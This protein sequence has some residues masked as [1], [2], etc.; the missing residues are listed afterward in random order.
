ML[1][2][3]RLF[4]SLTSCAIA[5]TSLTASPQPL[6]KVRLTSTF[7]AIT[8]ERPI[9]MS[10]APDDSGRLFVIEQAGRILAIQKG[11]DGSAGTEFLNI[12]NRHPYMT[13]EEGLMSIAFHP[14]FKTNGLFYIYYNQENTGGHS[15]FPR[16]SV[17]SEMKVSADNP[18]ALLTLPP[19]ES[20]S[21]CSNR[22]SII[23]AANCALG[24][25][26]SYISAL[27]TEGRAAIRS[28][29]ARTRRRSW[30]RFCVLM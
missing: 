8:F 27:V 7:P 20:S 19:S 25:T 13:D 14:G 10:E 22:L 2:L 24:L 9:W 17:I 16:R 3:K 30:E 6:P 11:T 12:T 15:F 5:A 28:T 1:I 26:D 18:N 4:L 21:K 29:T 23:R